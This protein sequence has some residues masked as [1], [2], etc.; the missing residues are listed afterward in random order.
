M[1]RLFRQRRRADAG[2]ASLTPLTASGGDDRFVDTVKR[3]DLLTPPS[4]IATFGMPNTTQVFSSAPRCGRRLLPFRQPARTV[5]PM[6]VMMMPVADGPAHIA[7]IGKDIDRWPVPVDRR[8][9]DDIDGNGW[10]RGASPPCACRPV[11]QSVRGPVRRGRRPSPRAR[12][13]CSACP[14]AQRRSP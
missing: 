8:T 6:P 10:G 4:S 1:F 12:E 5:V 14:V 11:T 3:Q 2:G 7:T 13:S 9:I